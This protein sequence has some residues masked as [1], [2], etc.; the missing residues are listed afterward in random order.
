[1]CNIFY[2]THLGVQFEIYPAHFPFD[3]RCQSGIL[4]NNFHI[5]DLNECHFNNGNC[6]HH[7]TNT[8][9]SYYCTCNAGYQLST[10]KHSCVG[11]Y[12][13]A[14]LTLGILYHT[15]SV[16]YF[17]IVHLGMQYKVYPAHFPFDLR[18]QSGICIICYETITFVACNV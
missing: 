8:D 9:G 12:V 17:Y 14:S 5:T 6:A 13:S 10:D 2:I 4:I 18:C 11:M 1:M 3:L 7:C 15:L 16:Q